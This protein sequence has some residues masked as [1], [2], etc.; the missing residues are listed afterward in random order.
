[1]TGLLIRRR[2]SL[3]TLP[4]TCRRMHHRTSPLIFHP[5][6]LHPSRLFRSTTDALETGRGVAKDTVDRQKVAN[7]HWHL[8][9]PPNLRSPRDRLKRR[10]RLGNPASLPSRSSRLLLRPFLL[11]RQCLVHRRLDRARARRSLPHYHQHRR[12]D[13]VD[14]RLRAPRQSHL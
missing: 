11:H 14:L 12:L 1:M 4:P 9:S 2:I 3:R 13:R 6:S 8:R 10:A 5:T 7:R